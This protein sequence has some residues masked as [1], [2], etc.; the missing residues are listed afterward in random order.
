ML[1]EFDQIVSSASAPLVTQPDLNMKVI[2]IIT[3]MSR[4]NHICSQYIWLTYLDQ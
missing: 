2:I 1:T 3:C 4:D